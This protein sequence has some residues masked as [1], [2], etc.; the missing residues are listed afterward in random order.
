VALRSYCTF[1]ATDAAPVSVNAQLLALF[2]P[3]EQAPDQ[4]AS[5]PFETV[6]VIDVPVVNG[7]DPVLPTATLIPTGLDVTLSP[8]RP[9]AVTVSVAV[10]A[11]GVTV[12][13]AVRVTP[14]AVAVMV[15][16][17]DAVTD[18]VPMVRVALVAPAATVTL[19]GTVAAAL[20]LESVTPN[21]PAGAADVNVTVPCANV[22]PATLA[23]LTETAVSEAGGGGGI[24]VSVPAFVA[25]PYAPVI[26]TDVDAPT[27]AVVTL[28]VA[29]VAPAATVTLAGT[30]ATALLLLD[31]VTTAP[32]A[33]AAVVNVADPCA[34]VPPTTVVGLRPI[35]D[36]AAAAGAALGWKRRATDH[37]P[38]VPAELKP[39]TRHQCGTLANPP[40]VNCEGVTV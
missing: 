25:P 2:P 30:V 26:V 33:G 4:I 11:G 18:V 39:R 10:A 6:S 38:A 13:A 16:T 1:A 31:S 7:A 40:V 9:V 17:V 23:G 14:A 20:L 24:T 15:A 22:P 32:P 28:N 37:G 35:A 29:L 27:A 5:R 8:P 34:A 3:L 21:P 12:N 19:A 36:S